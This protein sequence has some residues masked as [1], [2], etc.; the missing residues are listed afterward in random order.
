MF[1][2]LKNVLVQ[3]MVMVVIN[4]VNVFKE[5]VMSMQPVSIKAVLVIPDINHH[6]VFNL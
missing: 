6:Y 1:V 3:I 5:R 4:H 2:Y